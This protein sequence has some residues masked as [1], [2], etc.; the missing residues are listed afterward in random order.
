MTLLQSLPAVFD[1]P[2]L[3][4][5][6]VLAIFAVVQ[7]Q[8]TL[9][10]TE[11]R[12]LHGLKRRILPVVDRYTS[13]FV[14]SRKGGDD[15]A[16]YLCSVDGDV[17]RTFK[18]L[19]D[20]GGSPHLINALK[21]RPVAGGN[22]YSAAHVVFFHDDGQ[23][24]EAYLFHGK[25][26]AETDVYVHVEPGVVDAKDHLEGKQRDGDPRGVVREALK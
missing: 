9:S 1:D 6:L 13:L 11:Y 24:T 22:Q 8:R 5:V 18:R 16:E 23:Q 10:W 21:V 26:A 25:H 12:Y 4:A 3:Y 19:V 2:V 17:S 15:D 14:V 20:G 7:Y